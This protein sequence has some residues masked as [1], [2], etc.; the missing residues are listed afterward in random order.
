MSDGLF[1]ALSGAV[2]QTTQLDTVSNNLANGS[3]PGFRADR[4][5]FKQVMSSA[6]APGQSSDKA[7]VTVDATQIDTSQGSLK[8]TGNSLDVALRGPGFIAV[9]TAQGERYSRGGTLHIDGAGY[10]ANDSGAR[11]LDMNNSAIPAGDATH[12]TITPFGEVKNGDQVLGTMKLVQFAQPQSLA[13]EGAGLFNGGAQKAIEADARTQVQAG[14]L[15]QSNA[16]PLEEMIKLITL[17]RLYDTQM[18]VVQSY[19]EVDQKTTNDM[20]G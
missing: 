17:N 19:Q 7:Y 13:H 9:Q 16:K 2:A 11:V 12:I 10:V 1:A 5:T 3:T 8:E 4:V 14:A 18:S 6:L 15:E 20:G